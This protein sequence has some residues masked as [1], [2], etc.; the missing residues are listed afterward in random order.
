M[1]SQLTHTHLSNICNLS[2]YTRHLPNNMHKLHHFYSLLQLHH[3]T[4]SHPF[5]GGKPP[6][7][8]RAVQKNAG[9]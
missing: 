3:V 5:T 4:A 1:P 6:D 2:P 9:T 8:G 7:R